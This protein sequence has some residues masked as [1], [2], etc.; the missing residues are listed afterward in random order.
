M[1]LAFRSSLAKLGFE[2]M[3]VQAL[4]IPA[5]VLAILAMMMLPLPAI[6]LDVLFTFN[7]A[8]SIVV[9]MVAAY[10]KKAL[11]FSVFPIV[12]LLTTLM[13]LSL[14]VA[15]TRIVLSNGH[16]GPDAAGK[17]I[18]SFGHVMIGGNF[19]VGII[20]FAIL[21]VI[22]F[23]VITKGAGRIAEVS[24]RFTLDALP[25]KQM[26]IDADL[27]AG[28][29]DQNQAR[30]RRREVSDEADFY[31]A[32]DGASKYIRG[33]AIAGILILFI[34]LIGGMVIGMGWHGLAVS[35]AAEVYV[36]L[37]I[38][39]AL[40]A[41]VPAMIISI[42][43]GLIVTRVGGDDGEDVGG[44]MIRQVFS[45][46]KA[47][48][49]SAGVMALLGIIPGMPHL[50]FLLIAACCGYAAWYMQKLAN[51]KVAI[52]SVPVEDPTLSPGHNQEASWEDLQPVDQ[53]GLEVGY[54]LISLV[55]KG[56]DGE[57]LKRIKAIRKKFA[58]DVGFLPPQVHI[59]DNLEMKPSMYRIT[60]KGVVMG[61]G[62]VYPG[63]HMAIN[64]G[65]ATAVIEG[66]AA[67]DP[68]FGL[69]A[70]WIETKNRES[71][72]LSGY[73]VV[74]ASTVIA[75]HLSQVL[76]SQAAQLLGRVETMALIEHFSKV[77]PK[78]IDDVVPKL[79]SVA[80]FQKV[81]QSLLAEAIHIRDLRTII[82]VLA[83]VAPRTQDPADLVAA[84]RIAL[85]QSIVQQIYGRTDELRV[86]A[87]NP[88][89][90]RMLLNAVSGG[91]AEFVLEPGLAEMIFQRAT[92]LSDQQENAGLPPVLLVPDRLRTPLARL[93]KRVAPRLRVISHTE[94]PDTSTIRVESVLGAN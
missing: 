44:Q 88:D 42:A 90:E 69:P 92:E 8:L 12:L 50:V 54:R 28:V 20:L 76:H 35:K 40:V 48:A 63:M 14:N 75:T 61:E 3:P 64:P 32:M 62:D 89:I 18:E 36:L 65:H 33:D 34:T 68:A 73:T 46:P 31:G 13:R 17:V 70:I 83:A 85:G 56:Q 72:Q 77:L 66:T 60:V 57:L 26:A 84:C 24:A 51:E 5:F 37:A 78:L 27:N 7:I 15:S 82:E 25:G 22:N 67:K 80:V 91:D 9:L 47:L 29:I 86:I 30:E 21:M 58:Q 11:D 59:K 16:T 79:V 53:L 38:G 55:D 2:G 74:D 87:L 43:A 23:I 1:M 4:A 94:I 52:A 19:A 39:D 45:I 93:L 81:L 6:L 41:S 71:A 49:I 10:T